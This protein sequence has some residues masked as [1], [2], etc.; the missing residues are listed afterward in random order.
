MSKDPDRVVPLDW[1][2]LVGE[3]IRRRRLEGMTQR[4]HAALANVS[5]PTISAFDKGE[6]SLTLSKAMDILRVVGLVYDISRKD[7]QEIFVSEAHERWRLLTSGL[8]P[9]F[10]YARFPNGWYRVDYEI[11]GDLKS[12][13]LKQFRQIL[14]DA[15]VRYSGWP[16]FW[17][18]TR[19]G[20]RP[21]EREGLLECWLAPIDP[22]KIFADAAHSDFWRVS[23]GG[24]AFLI[25]GYQEDAQ[26]TFPSGSIFDTSL[27][28]WRLG[29]CLLHAE[30][31]AS[32]LTKSPSD[33]SVRFRA[34]Y[35]GLRGRHLAAWSN[36]LNS[37]SNIGQRSRS[38]E[39]VLQVTVRIEDISK[40]LTSIV[41]KLVSSL[42]ERFGVAGL[43]QHF[44][45]TE[46]EKMQRN[47]M[48]VQYPLEL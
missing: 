47:R 42:Y 1:A 7:V 29:E 23:P 46:L 9:E 35:T 15:T 28:I 14:S 19:D 33:A 3:A 36:P 30:S 40:D 18:P 8:P 25:R 41:Y 11:D 45:A 5:L 26:E 17:V 32:R 4:E 13:D 31:L 37:S 24:R 43:S 6:E 21:Y 2:S 44:V 48:D 12:A 39:A 16:P 22:E 34:M 10:E 38:D 20:I 27:P